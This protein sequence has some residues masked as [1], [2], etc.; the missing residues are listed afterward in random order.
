LGQFDLLTGE[1]LSDRS[2]EQ[3]I[4]EVPSNLSGEIPKRNADATYGRMFAMNEYCAAA[5]M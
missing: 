2:A 4:D 3:A 1:L 5:I